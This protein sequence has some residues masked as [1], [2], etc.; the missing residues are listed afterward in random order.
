VL[1]DQ[2]AEPVTYVNA[3]SLAQS[4]GIEVRLLTDTDI[5]RFRNSIKLTAVLDDGEVVS[6]EGTLTGPM[7]VA[8]LVGIDEHPLEIA[9]GDHLL[10][11]RYSDRPGM[12]GQSGVNIAGMVVGRDEVGG[13]AV[14]VLTLDGVVPA[15]LVAALRTAI[16]ADRLVYADLSAS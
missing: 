2:V 1:T 5:A 16:Q 8:K 3:P 14:S 13:R 10:V 6:V 11:M 9:F 15:D 12:L 7:Q 4:R